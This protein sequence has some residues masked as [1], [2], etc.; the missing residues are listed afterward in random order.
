MTATAK[1]AG[2]FRR[3]I[4]SMVAAR[5]R[6][7]EFYVNSVLLSFDD[8]TLHAHGYSRAELL[9]RPRASRHWL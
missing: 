9:G 8:D 2:F 3:A 4:R 5:E 7:A 6:Q 1:K